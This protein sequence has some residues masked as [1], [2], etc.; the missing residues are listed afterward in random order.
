MISLT[1]EFCGVSLQNCFAN[2]SGPRCVTREE[3][4]ALSQS[5]AAFVVSK[6]CTIEPREGNPEPR[7]RDTPFGSINSMGLPNLGYAFYSG[8]AAEIAKGKPYFV[9]VSGMKPEDNLTIIRELARNSAIAAIE[10][11]LSCPNLVGKPQIGYDFSASDQLLRDALHAAEGKPLG[12]KLPPYFD[13]IHFEQMAAVLNKHTPAFITCINSIGNGL[14]IDPETES[15]VIRPKGGFGG[16]GGDYI[17]PTALAN[18]RKFRELLDPEIAIVGCG[19]IKNGTDAFEFILAGAQVVQ[20]GTA[21]YREGS[22]IFTRLN[23]ELREIMQRKGYGTLDSYRG[24]L[25]VV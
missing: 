2:A 1:T 7:Y 14:V 20:V 10:L 11:N 21:L 9:S 15:A 22:A 3:L 18:V 12:C 23:A 4:V 6:S 13:F 24:K 17:K 19:G 16:I 25:K 8:I 5:D